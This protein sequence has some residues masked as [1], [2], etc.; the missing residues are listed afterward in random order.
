MTTYV[1][2]L[3]G[4]N[5]SGQ[6]AIRMQQLQES[7]AQLG[8]KRIQTYLQS[9]NIVFQTRQSDAAALARKIQSTILQDFGHDVAVLVLSAQQIDNVAS[10]NPLWPRS[11]GDGR[12]FHGTFLFD[13]IPPNNFA[14]LTLPAAGD[15]RAVLVGNVVLLHCP[16]G[17]GKSKLNNSFFERKLGVS[18][19]TRNWSTVLA[20]QEL[21]A[22]AS[23]R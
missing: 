9:G 1:A 13:S 4:I 7:L 15:E 20:L 2:L 6:K 3:R 23:L 10:S 12:F 11:G 22:A 14:K 19:T 5:V 8:L 16:N 17:Y 18:A 21:C